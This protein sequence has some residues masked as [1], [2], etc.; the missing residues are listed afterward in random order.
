MRKGR[1]I[2]W[3][4]FWIRI[5]APLAVAS[6]LFIYFLTGAFTIHGYK[7]EGATNEQAALL[8]EQFGYLE[9]QRLF[10]LLPGNRSISYHD[11]EMRNAIMDLLPNTKEISIR[12]VNAHTLS[13]KLSSYEPIFSVSDT[14][15][16]SKDGTVYKEIMPL[17]TFVRLSIATSTEVSPEL[18]R[19][20]DELARNLSTVLFTVRF[21][22]VD[23]WNDIRFYDGSGKAHVIVSSAADM[24][25]AWSNILSAIDTDPLKRKLSTDIDH[26]DYIDTRFGNKVFYKFT[27]AALP[28]IIPHTDESTATT[29]SQ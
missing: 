14:H 9:E 3:K 28:A 1:R 16:I 23:E 20:M 12:P 10:M 26:L 29:T 22:T 15:A 17:E 7:I 24:K 13:V 21:I 4:K 8:T 11:D 2:L 19:S 18:L 27:N 6:F 25:K 5:G